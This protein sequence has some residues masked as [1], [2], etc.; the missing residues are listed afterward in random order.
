MTTTFLPLRST[1]QALSC[2]STRRRI[3]GQLPGRTGIRVKQLTPSDNTADVC[4]GPGKASARR[5]AFTAFHTATASEWMSSGALSRSKWRYTW[6]DVFASLPRAVP[7]RSKI[8][9]SKSFG[10]PNTSPLPSGVRG[11]A[12]CLRIRQ[13]AKFQCGVCHFP[14][15]P[16]PGSSKT[17]DSRLLDHD[18]ALAAYG[19][20]CV[21]LHAE[22]YTNLVA[23]GLLP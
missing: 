14:E 12:L 11:I 13:G 6:K 5:R 17:H 8:E 1:S 2:Q 18:V 16:G 22:P 19:N 10:F 21:R 9:P 15:I 23:A 7:A 20:R 3:R 4:P